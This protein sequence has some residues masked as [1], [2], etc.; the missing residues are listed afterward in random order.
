MSNTKSIVEKNKE[1][2][3]FEE[4]FWMEDNDRDRNKDWVR[5]LKVELKRIKKEN[6]AFPKK[7][8]DLLALIKLYEKK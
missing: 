4:L 2:L 8:K 5:C 6:K 3:T 7:I 1:G